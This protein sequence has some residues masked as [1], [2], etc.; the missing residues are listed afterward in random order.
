LDTLPTSIAST[1]QGR[2]LLSSLRRHQRRLLFGG[3]GLVSLL[4]LA[5]LLVAVLSDVD[6][7][8]AAQQRRFAE[9][10]ASVDYFLLQ[11][12]RAYA[13]NINGSEAMW[14]G[15]Q[16]L[17]QAQG[18]PLVD[19]FLA[20]GSQLM[21]RAEGATAVPWLVLGAK[22]D[23]LP[24]PQL[25]AYLGIMAEY[26]AYTAATIT[27]LRASGPVTMYLYEPQGRLLA[28]AG[29]ADEAQ[30]LHA[31]RVGSREE[32]F[33]RLLVN[34]ERARTMRPLA[35]PVE[36]AAG[37]GRLISRFDTNP[38]TGQPSLVGVQTL[39]Q[40]REPAFRRIVFEPVET[41]KARL[42]ERVSGAYAVVTRDGRTVLRSAGM[43]RDVSPAL[44]G[45]IAAAGGGDGRLHT[46]GQFIVHG[47]VHG[48]DWTVLHLYGWDDLWREKG[49][50][51]LA[52]A[53]ASAVILLALWLLLLRL[54]RRVFT[55]ALADASRVYESEALSRVIIDTSPVGLVLIDPTS[56]EPLVENEPARQM[57]ALVGADG[58]ALYALLATRAR[59]AVAADA[60]AGAAQEFQW[61]AEGAARHA[62]ELQVAMA[63]ASFRD[64]PVWVC[65]LRDVTAQAELERTLRDA[66]SD[67]ERARA[68]A[69]SASHAKSAF[70]AT[71]SHEIRTPLNG[72]LGHLELLARAPMQPAQQERVE[73]IRLSADALLGIISDVLDFSKIEAG[74]LDI[75]PVAFEPRPLIEQ[76]ALLFSAQAQRKG[77]KLYYA[78]DPAL[79]SVFVAD[80]QRI[81]QVLN[82]LLGNAVKFTESGRIVVRAALVERPSAADPLLRLQVV[83]SGIGLAEDQLAQLFQPFQQADTSISRRYGG[84]G[85]G[86]AL[87]QQLARLLGGSIAA[88]STLGVGSVFTL[89]VPVQR[90]QAPGRPAPALAGQHITLLSAAAEW[91]QEIGGLLQRA[92]AEVTVLEQPPLEPVAGEN[93]TL[94]LFGERRAWSAED[95]AA[96]VARHRHVVR[97]YANGPLSPQQMADGVHVSC[98]AGQALLR[99]LGALHGNLP[100]GAPA[101]SALAASAR[102][103]VLLVEDNPINRELIQQQLEAL[104]FSVDT[105]ED[106]REG[107]L[108]WRQHE[109]LAVLTDINMPV[110]DGYALARALRERSASVP[111]LAITAT[112][113]ASERER[114]RQAGITDLLLK[115]LNLDT[116]G[117]VLQHH[118]GAMPDAA[119]V[120]EL[121]AAPADDLAPDP[122][123]ALPEHLRRTFVTSSVDDLQRI[124]RARADQDGP[125]LLDRV[126]ALKGVLMMLGQRELGERFSV[127][128]AQLRDGGTADAAMLD[129]AIEAL[130][131]LVDQ[132]AARLGAG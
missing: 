5:T 115:P 40:G 57:A 92:G 52:Q 101:P 80:L 1:V 66:R 48:V 96:L 67:A 29:V 23:P 109:H 37:S 116:L 132:Q 68:A 97:A 127:L 124:A 19:R 64:R 61:N 71:M 12:D 77:V 62:L 32:A 7:F 112:A 85:L 75:D 36:S 4:I 63:P 53:L 105:A 70:V 43:P 31:L 59:A 98:F 76:A 83:D 9:A 118:L 38:I 73:R 30:L 44:A 41:I 99:A 131:A 91:R 82:N 113:L 114:C 79:D 56:G 129:A 54:H 16:A 26:S 110:M 15:Q 117:R 60:G 126:H 50:R 104:G 100:T 102:G 49:G 21:V 95:E 55:P 93:A 58:D 88:E 14:N 130:Q 94:L 34:E 25:D 123:T 24:R 35:G 3:G 65:A 120:A 106:G 128:E 51:L 107:L 119:G 10:R 84:S 13:A 6:A 33:A 46:G 86:L 78:L 17:L 69:E 89:D 28:V 20:S 111:I 72:V 125:A 74:Q 121:A 87:C 42:D 39:L 122:A 103:R 47:P 81:R 8:H 45:R 22:D 18:R 2:S 90:G 108:A 11:R 27:A